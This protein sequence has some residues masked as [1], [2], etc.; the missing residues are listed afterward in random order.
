MVG[1]IAQKIDAFGKGFAW[2]IKIDKDGNRVITKR[3][4]S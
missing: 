3:A 4:V 1:A 2:F